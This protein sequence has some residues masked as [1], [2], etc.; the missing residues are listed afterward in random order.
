[1]ANGGPTLTHVPL[2]GSP[3]I[4]AGDNSDLPPTDQRGYPRIADATGSGL[5]IDD[6]GAVEDGL[7]RLRTVPQTPQDIL[8]N[9]F[10]M[11][12]T[13]ES[14]RFYVIQSSTNLTVWRNVS[15]NLVPATELPVYDTSAG[16][17][18]KR[19]YR[20]HSLPQS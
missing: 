7:V 6:I 12:L 8:L 4:N 9:G 11:F 18:G 19:S 13:G 10:R 15:T 2:N 14:N 20:A 17:F 5:E 3:A 1:M 16:P